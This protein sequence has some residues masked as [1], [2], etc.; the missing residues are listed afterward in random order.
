M[1]RFSVLGGVLVLIAIRISI[2]PS[3]L[4]REREW[5][6]MQKKKKFYIPF[7]SFYQNRVIFPYFDFASKKQPATITHLMDGAYIA[8]DLDDAK[9]VF[10]KTLKR[11]APKDIWDH[12]GYL[13]IEA[14]DFDNACKTFTHDKKL[15]DYILYPELTSNQLFKI[16]QGE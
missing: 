14:D 16:I 12:W 6:H 8:D 11:I 2:P 9:S 5:R 3:L 4:R 1:T 15:C 13:E 10:K 7:L